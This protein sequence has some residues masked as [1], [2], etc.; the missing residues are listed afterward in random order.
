MLP[1]IRNFLLAHTENKTILPFHSL[2]AFGQ[3]AS[4]WP[5]IG[6][7]S[8]TK[9]PTKLHAELIVT[10]GCIICVGATFNWS[11]MEVC[12]AAAV[13]PHGVC[14]SYANAFN[15][16]TVKLNYATLRYF[17]EL[18]SDYDRHTLGQFVCLIACSKL[19]RLCNYPSFLSYKVES[20]C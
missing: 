18:P 5:L 4:W 19:R 11:R 14:N 10:K 12:P 15:Y 20:S 8:K 1:S 16:K 9:P 2:F 6:V 3:L 13:V 17:T 7:Q